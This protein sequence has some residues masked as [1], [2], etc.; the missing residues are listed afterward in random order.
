MVFGQFQYD[1][2]RIPR[3]QQRYDIE[4]EKF[5][6]DLSIF[7]KCSDSDIYETWFNDRWGIVSRQ[8]VVMFINS[9]VIVW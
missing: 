3:S 1:T 2:R 5:T 4:E 8:I 9:L 7:Y 6:R